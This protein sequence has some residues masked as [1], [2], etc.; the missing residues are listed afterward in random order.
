LKGLLGLEALYADE[1]L[2]FIIQ[3]VG[4]PMSYITV[5]QQ[6]RL[7]YWILKYLEPFAGQEEE[8]LVLEKRRHRYV[9]L[10]TKYMIECSLPL[11]CGLD[12][13]PEDTI[14][15]KFERVKARSDTLVLS[16][17]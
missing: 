1:E 3:A 9:V 10:L 11:D 13:K 4:Q 14:L 16:L 7:R 12:L 5:L 17:A 15:V 6:E 2:A 8:A